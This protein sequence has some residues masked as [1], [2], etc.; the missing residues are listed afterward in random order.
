[1]HRNSPEEKGP[2]ASSKDADRAG[3]LVR[4]ERHFQLTP[5][6]LTLS[7]QGRGKVASCLGI[8]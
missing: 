4:P 7:P 8:E 6:S 5:L 1:M 3:S 2:G